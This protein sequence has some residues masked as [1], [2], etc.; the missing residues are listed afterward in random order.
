MADLQKPILSAAAVGIVPPVPSPITVVARRLS[1]ITLIFGF[2]SVAFFLLLIFL[3]IPF[4][5]YPLISWQDTLDLLTPLVLIPIYWMMYRAVASEKMGRAGESIFMVF[6]SIWILGQGMHLAANSID[7]LIENLAKTQSLNILDTDVYRLTYFIDEELSHYI[8]HIGVLGLAGL[9]I[10]SYWRSG[11]EEKT[12][13]RLVIPAGILYGAVCFCIF[14]EGQTS[15]MSFP[16][17]G[18]AS[19]FLLVWARKDLTKKPVLAFFTI[20]FLL[21]F[22]GIA[23]WSIMHGAFPPPE[24]LK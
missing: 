13:W 17:L 1:L 15:L 21:A 12:D 24:L 20:A 5:L 14:I 16:M 18:L 3:R 10:Y 23:V 11:S 19:L 4:P 9:L 2:C 7:N 22:V 8:W 6:A